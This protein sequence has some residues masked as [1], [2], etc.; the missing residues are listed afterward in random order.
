MRCPVCDSH[1]SR[2]IESRPLDDGR[3]I[4]RRRSCRACAHRF[5]TY[6]HVEQSAPLVLKADGRR[7]AF[8]RDKVM[9]GLQKACAKR[10]VS[11]A[12]L[13]RI[14]DDLEARLRAS[15]PQVSSRAIGELVA[16]QLRQVDD[17][18]YVRFASVYGRFTDTGAFRTEIDRLEGRTEE[19]ASV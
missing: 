10:P 19:P 8:D 2:V 15:G 1:D 7:E 5:T 16:E 6:E 12:R 17:V 3:A 18:A 13:T 11:A 4:R 9:L 14:V